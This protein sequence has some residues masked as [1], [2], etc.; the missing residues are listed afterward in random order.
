MTS[1]P[2]FLFISNVV[3]SREKGGGEVVLYRHFVER[4]LYNFKIIDP[5]VFLPRQK[6]KKKLRSIGERLERTRLAAYIYPFKPFYDFFDIN[7]VLDSYATN[8]PLFIVTV[9]HN[10]MCYRA[11]RLSKKLNIPLVTFFHDWF[12]ASTVCAKWLNFFIVKE[13]RNLYHHSTIALCVSEQIKKKLGQ[14]PFSIVLPPIPS[15]IEGDFHQKPIELSGKF[16]IL[17]AGFCGGNYKPML[18]KV[19]NLAASFNLFEL[20]IA[21]ER[22]NE[23]KVHEKPNVRIL[24]FIEHTDLLEYIRKSD[25][26]LTLIPFDKT[27]KEHY[28]THFPSKLIEYAGYRRPIII[29]GPSYSTAIQWGKQNNSA[30]VIEDSSEAAFVETIKNLNNDLLNQVTYNARRFYDLNWE[31][32][33]IQNRLIDCLN[34]IYE[35]NRF[36][37]KHK[38]T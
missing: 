34:K 24:G 36:R 9:A 26:L 13:F 33:I 31:P 1:E 38:K 25:F 30:I 4:Q 16:T 23:L 18:E 11:Q 35:T 10:R 3:P 12:P 32:E 14:H 15:K 22:S 2:F 28:S 21:G 19:I 17:Y 8:K 29:W 5:E 20:Y 6:W 27:M 37:A 7:Q